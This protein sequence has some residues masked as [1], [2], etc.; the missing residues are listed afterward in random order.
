MWFYA[1]LAWSKPVVGTSRRLSDPG[2]PSVLM[3]TREGHDK[4][5][6]PPRVKNPRG[7]EEQA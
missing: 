7:P 4:K 3:S 6:V 1:L 2:R 5:I